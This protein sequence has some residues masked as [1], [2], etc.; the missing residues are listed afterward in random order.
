MK[1]LLLLSVLALSGLASNAQTYDYFTIKVANGDEKSFTASGLKITFTDETMIVTSGS[2]SMKYSLSDL[3]KMFFATNPTAVEAVKTNVT[4]VKVSLVGGKLSVQAPEGS[5]IH[6]YTTDGR[7]VS[8]EGVFT[9]G[10]YIIRVNNQ[11]FKVLA[12]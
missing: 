2:E 6:A 11:S 8:T 5:S 1:K 12:Q 9:N 7:E 10:V 3:N 4:D